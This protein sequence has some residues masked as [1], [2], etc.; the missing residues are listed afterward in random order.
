MAC[1]ECEETRKQY[2]IMRRAVLGFAR[3][4]DQLETDRVRLANQDRL[5]CFP[6]IGVLSEAALKEAGLLREDVG[7]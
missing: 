7:P 4:L 1:P 2:L 5:A 6:P 3:S